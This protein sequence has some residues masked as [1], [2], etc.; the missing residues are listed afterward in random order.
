MKKVWLVFVLLFIVTAANFT[1]AGDIF[2]TYSQL[3]EEAKSVV[4]NL[5]DFQ[6]FVQYFS[7]ETGSGIGGWIY[8]CKSNPPLQNQQN[9]K[10]FQGIIYKTKNNGFKLVF[11]DRTPEIVITS[12]EF[13]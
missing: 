11:L 13:K 6:E 5:N 4:Q 10:F 12:K 3:E 8:F 7:I 2:T 9:G 1:V